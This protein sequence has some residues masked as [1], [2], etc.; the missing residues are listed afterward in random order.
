MQRSVSTRFEVLLGIVK[1]GPPE[2]IAKSA[3]FAPLIST[4]GAV[5]IKSAPPVSL[6]VKNW[7]TVVPCNAEPKLI[8]LPGAGAEP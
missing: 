7:V 6:I 1:G 8:T 2:T 3:V 4:L 5:T